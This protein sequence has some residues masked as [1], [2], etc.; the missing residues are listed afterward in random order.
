MRM[1]TCYI[2]IRGTEMTQVLWPYENHPQ[3]G[4]IFRFQDQTYVIKD[5]EWNLT[6]PE[7]IVYAE[8]R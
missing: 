3:A 7:L 2:H 5:R 1:V 6:T 4:D 8:R